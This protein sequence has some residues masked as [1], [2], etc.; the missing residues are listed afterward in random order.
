[1][2]FRPLRT[3]TIL[4]LGAV[5][6]CQSIAPTAPPGPA[7]SGADPTLTSVVAAPGALVTERNP[8]PIETV[9]GET[10]PAASFIPHEL[11]V[12]MDATADT[13]AIA[14][15]A[16]A[17]IADDLTFSG[18][19]ARL[20]LP[21]GASLTEAARRLQ[22]TPGV[23]GVEFNW[24]V[25][26][27]YLSAATAQPNNPSF[28]SQWGHRAIHSVDAW[29]LLGPGFSAAGTII[30]VLDTGLDTS[31][32]KFA[33]RILPG[34]NLTS[35]NPNTAIASGSDVTDQ[36]GHGTHV[37]GIAAAM[38]NDGVGVCGLAWDAKILPVKVLGQSGGSLYT[39]MKGLHAIADYVP[40]AGSAVRAANLSLGVEGHFAT[41]AAMED[42][43]AYAWRHGIVVV[44]AAGNASSDVTNP[45]VNPHGIA[46]SAT[47]AG[48]WST[49]LS[50]FGPG[51]SLSD[52]GPGQRVCERSRPG[53][54]RRMWTS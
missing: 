9:G 42:A 13:R 26:P 18:R 27:S 25:T 43:M 28:S 46:V 54:C 50:F 8:S 2:S 52:Y 35:D 37:A 41:D 1:M 34:I 21:A 14:R 15:Q 23:R 30:A 45:A 48:L 49:Q 22:T 32:P 3:A 38:G 16:S 40:P 7:V 19:Y 53:R 12:A 33:G 10:A 51:A 36:A 24:R 47:L 29:H 4:A 11:V 44:V 20:V 5:T 31:H 6:A 39:V 17:S